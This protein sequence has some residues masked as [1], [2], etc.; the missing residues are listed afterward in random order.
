MEP[1]RMSKR[2]LAKLAKRGKY[3]FC[4]SCGRA[5]DVGDLVHRRAVKYP[6]GGYS[7]KYFCDTCESTGRMYAVG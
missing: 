1:I 2:V 4:Q 7:V 3:P 6:N 5:I